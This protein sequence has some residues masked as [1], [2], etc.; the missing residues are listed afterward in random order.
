MMFMMM[1]M[2]RLASDA[3]DDADDVV[4]DFEAYVTEWRHNMFL[5]TAGDALC[6]FCSEVEQI[7]V[8]VIVFKFS[9]S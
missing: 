1:L 3:D 9:R 6:L 8:P 7:N 4:D 5:A 2:V